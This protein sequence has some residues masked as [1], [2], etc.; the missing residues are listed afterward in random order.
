MPRVLSSYAIYDS[1]T[2]HGAQSYRSLFSGLLIMYTDHDARKN[3]RCRCYKSYDQEWIIKNR[4]SFIEYFVASYGMIAGVCG[5]IITM[6]VGRKCAWWLQDERVWTTNDL[7]FHQTEQGDSWF[8]GVMWPTYHVCLLEKKLSI[9]RFHPW[10]FQ[11]TY[12]FYR[13]FIW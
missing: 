8:L 1:C 10:A 2:K 6:F 3:I 4:W 5:S 13:G 12:L 7:D 11:Q 9:L